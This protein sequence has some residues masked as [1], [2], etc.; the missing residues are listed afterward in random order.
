M[1]NPWCAYESSEV[2]VMSA[3]IAVWC[4]REI[5]QQGRPRRRH[6]QDGRR[7]QQLHPREQSRQIVY[8]GGAQAHIWCVR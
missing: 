5:G 3:G 2:D 6:A 7:G 8:R 4:C 1:I